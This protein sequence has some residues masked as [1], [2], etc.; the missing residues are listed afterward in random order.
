M[1]P[2]IQRRKIRRAGVR[3]PV[4]ILSLRTR[5]EGEIE[6]VSSE[7]AF[8]YCKEV[9]PLD[10]IFS[11]VIKAPRHRVL[12]LAGEVVW[13]TVLNPDEGSPRFGLGVRFTRVS[14]IDRQY[15]I[16]LIRK[17][18]ELKGS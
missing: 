18:H 15:L 9:P 17:C 10:G 4:T 3:W 13:S 12:N 1:I 14:P 5:V 8:V 6:N 16:Y 7:G 2:E 11:V